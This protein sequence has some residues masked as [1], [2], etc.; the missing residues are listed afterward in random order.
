[1]RKLKRQ[2]G[3]TLIL[4]IGIV[5]TLAIMATTLVFVIGNMSANSGTERTRTKAFDVAEGALDY[6]MNM[7]AASWPIPTTTT[8]TPSPPVFSVSS[9]QAIGKYANSL[10]YPAPQTG[11]GPFASVTYYDNTG[12]SPDNINFNSHI[13]A[14]GD[15]KMWLVTTGATGTRTST[16]QSE[17]NRNTYNTNFPTGIA[18]YTGGNLTSN[19]GG[20]NPKIRIEDQTNTPSVMGYVAGNLQAPSVF[21]STITPVVGNKVGSLDSLGFT[22]NLINQVIALAQSQNRYYDTTQGA[23][24]PT[25]LSGVCVVRVA[26]GTNV[27]L[28]NS[29]SINSLAAP[30]ILF[31]LGPA[32]NNLNNITVDMGGNA[33]FYGVM[34]TQGVFQSSHGTPT[35]HGMLVCASSLD[36]KGTPQILYNASVIAN[37]AGC[38]TLSVNLLP[39]TWRQ[40]KQ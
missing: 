36:M 11:L 4:V 8:P 24:M 9:F 32:T 1:M 35:I 13:D 21:Q 5:A 15:G 16:I 12:T 19:G 28:G 17:V 39:N 31:I 2:E 18:V 22:S 20:N 10:E 40:T 30:G 29:G 38:W 6:G 23:S 3:V 26:N 33:Q 25:D 27:A 7:L 37:L 14:N 34:Y